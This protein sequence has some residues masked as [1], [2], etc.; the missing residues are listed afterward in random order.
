MTFR[1]RIK[2]Y[3][4]VYSR[5]TREGGTLLSASLAY[6]GL[7]ALAPAL[8]I[9]A[10]G[11]RYLLKVPSQG[12]ALRHALQTLFGEELA[13][14]LASAITVTFQSRYS[15]TASLIGL[16]VLLFAVVAAY[17]R[18][19]E[20]VSMVWGLRIPP[21]ARARQI[22]ARRAAQML[23][24]LVPFALLAF[25]A[26]ASSVL[27]ASPWFPIASDGLLR[28]LGSPLSLGLAAWVMS[29]LIYLLLPDA[30]VPWR[31]VILPSLAFAAAW[32]LG[33]YLA[34]MYFTRIASASLQGAV[35]SLLVTLIWLNYSAR[36]L[37]YGAA[38]CR[39]TV[40]RHDGVH[41]LAHAVYLSVPL[42]GEQEPS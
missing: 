9:M 4:A 33:T 15:T 26:I 37:L 34:G 10:L 13:D 20:A 29:A 11:A 23:I 6:Y 30:R 40:E 12:E 42:R 32:T 28:F 5:M 16:G 24:V 22:A 25:A 41:P 19:Q 36:A 18:L 1:R 2:W 8:V 27:A 3:I 35:G 31:A 38:L 39:A 14:A 17:F 21:D 7:F